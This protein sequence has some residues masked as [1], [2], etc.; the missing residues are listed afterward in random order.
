MEYVPPANRNGTEV[1][2]PLELIDAVV[3]G[4]PGC[5]ALKV[6]MPVG[7]APPTVDAACAVNVNVW[8]WIGL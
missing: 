7:I 2:M 3:V 5:T 6:I 1:A 4:K 8:P